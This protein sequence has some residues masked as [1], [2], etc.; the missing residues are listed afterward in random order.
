MPVDVK[1]LTKDAADRT[2]RALEELIPTVETVPASIHGA[3]RHST[4]AGASAC[5]HCW[6]IRPLSR[7][8]AGFRKALRGW[9]Q[10]PDAAYV[11]AD[12]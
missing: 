11:F 8:R 9:V 2:D 6:R 4:F 3:M 1:S 10:H 5:G 7:L 12:P